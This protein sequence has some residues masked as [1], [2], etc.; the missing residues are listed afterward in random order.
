MTFRPYD[1]EKDHEAAHRIW[2]E[3]GWI[4]DDKV[5]PMDLAISAGRANV[6]EV[7]GDAECLV[8]T[9][10]AQMRHLEED[11]SLI[12]VTAVTTSRVARKQG[13]AGRLTAQ[14]VAED[15][16]DGA[17]LAGLGIFDQGYY[18][19]LGFG[20]GPYTR[21]ARFDPAA[22][23]VEP[24]RRP[25]RR[26]TID[27]WE[28]VHSGRLIRR[29][30]H[31]SVNLLAPEMTHAEMIWSKQG[32]GL[33]YCDGPD[34]ALS[35]HV[36]IG[37]AENVENG[38]YS[39]RW[40]VFQTAD[41]LR[42]L[43]GVIRNLGDQVHGIR[44]IDPPGIQLQMFID[45]PFRLE[46]MTRK[47]RFDAKSESWSWMQFRICNLAEC[48][49]RTKLRGD[50]VRFNVKLADPIAEFLPD[51]A[52]WRGVAGE[53]VVT[54]GSSSG[55]EEGTDAALPTMIASVNAFTRL[56]LG[57]GPATGLAVTDDLDA[58]RELLEQ[59]DWVLRLPDPQPDWDF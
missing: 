35:H 24:A 43:L 16:A 17:L 54:L 45:R 7:N 12:A 3:I 2:R 6:A 30:G 32:F 59:L 9:A 57:V 25:P 41:Q 46:R 38:P 13:L 31:G 48:L 19:R 23:M 8:L 55:A 49:A 40:M 15:V 1:K 10:P 53:Y 58:P 34:G 5:E 28:L 26:L 52:P 29:R 4:E 14:S 33:G 56:W 51:D 42:E 18:D 47:S 22:L 39:V 20:N 36:W 27:D 11:L 50:E 44:V 21:I 37:V